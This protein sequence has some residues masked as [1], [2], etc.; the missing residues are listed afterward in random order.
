MSCSAT[1]VE[2]GNENGD[3]FPPSLDKRSLESS[4]KD[5]TRSLTVGGVLNEVCNNSSD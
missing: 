4:V 2:V 5:H 3:S 1:E